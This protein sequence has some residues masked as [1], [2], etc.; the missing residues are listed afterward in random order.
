M[1]LI[2]WKQIDPQLSGYGN[3]TGSLDISGSLRLNGALFTGGGGS[4][5]TLSVNG[6]DLSI[7]GGNTVTLPSGSGGSASTGSLINSA[8][9]TGNIIT[10]TKG[11]GS[12]FN[13]TIDTGSGGGS[14]DISALN[15]FTSSIQTEVDTLTAATSSY[16][17]SIDS[18]IVSSSAQVTELLP[19]GVVSGSSQITI[20]ES[21][22]SD[23]THYADSDVKTKLD[24]EGVLSGSL[25]SQLPTGIISGSDQLT[26]SYD[27]RY[28]LSGSVGGG[29]TDISALN[30]FTGSIQTQVDSLES[31]TGSYILAS[32]TSSMTVLSASYAVSSSH[33]IITEVSSSH[34][35]QADTA[36]FISDTFISES[37]VR[38][39][40]GSGGS[41]S[42]NVSYD[43]DRIVSNEDL[44]D[45]FTNNYNAGTSGSIQDF[46]NAVFFPNTA[47]T[48]TNSANF[49]IDEFIVSG[50]SVGTLTATDPEGQSLTFS[51]ASAYTSDFVKVSTAGAVTLNRVPTT[52]DFNTDNRGDGTLAHPVQ[53][54]VTDTFNTT[55][56]STIY[57]NVTANSAPV[58]RQTS[59]VG[60]IITSFT[61]NRNEND[62]A[63][64]NIGRIYFTDTNSD[65]ITI[66]SQSDGSGHFSITK[67]SNYVQ[68]AQV[69]SSLDYESITSYT[70]SITGSD[71]HYEA[72]QDTDAS[73]SLA[74]TIN[75]TDNLVP[76]V[77]NQTLDSISE[78]SSN[79]AT[80]DSITASDNE[81]DTIT[82]SNFTLSKL[83][84]DNV[85]V[86]TGSYGGTSQS[87]PHED[88]FQ[89]NS[90]GGVTRKTG[91]YINSDIINEYQYTVQVRD[92]Y[93]TISSPATITIPIT[94][95][96]A[97]SIG[98]GSSFYIIESAVNGDS[99]YDSTN[100]Y[101]GTTT[102]FTSNQSVTWTV[103]PTS[104][105]AVD[106]SGYLT[107]NRNISGSADVGG[108]QLNG[109]VT[110]SNGFGTI[111]QGTFTVNITDNTAPTITFTNTSA[112][113]NT[114]GARPSNTLV[115]ISF[116]DTEG[117]TID[118]TSFTFTDPSNQLT[119]TQSGNTF[120]VQPTS[121]LSGSTSYAITASIQDSEGFATRTSNHSFT[122]VQAPIGSLTTNG[123][124]RIIESAQSGSNIVTN[125]NGIPTGTQADLGVS[126]SPAYNSAVVQSFTSSNA[127]IAVDGSG[128]LSLGV[129]ISG[130]A[131]SSG[132]TIQSSIT[133][134]DQY[135]NIGSGSITINV[136][137]NTAP[138]VTITDNGLNT[139]TAVSGSNI[140]SIAI[141]DSE[142]DTPF[143]LSLTGAYG[144]SFN[145]IPQNAA[146]SS[147]VLQPTAS[148]SQ[149]SYAITASAQDTFS[150]TGT[151]TADITVTQAADYG[152]VYVYKVGNYASGYNVD[153][154]ISSEVAGT[155]PT[156]LGY[157]GLGFVTSILSGSL[158]SSSFTYSYGGTK[159]ASLAESSSGI[160]ALGE[161]LVS[162]STIPYSSDRFV[163]IAPS[164]SD[165]TVP[166][167]MTDSYGGSTDGEYV[168]EAATDGTA[169]GSGLGTTETS[170][171]HKLSLL[172]AHEGF[173]NWIMIGP[174][175]LITGT[176]S[177]LLDV[178]TSSGSA[179]S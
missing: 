121:N 135:D 39:G 50:S 144:G 137:E 168:L 101:S 103:N 156:A 38:S 10:F 23:L 123:T 167:S 161:T 54:K 2:K 100:G 145:T 99:V 134:R 6:Y 8:S 67:Y 132:D 48:F 131:T 51:T 104:D 27:S 136:T 114:N 133:Y 30:T 152:V 160:N 76:V 53:V 107:I 52:E 82:F 165:L 42:A 83:E 89:M 78:N 68:I 70:L 108:D 162:M 124:F 55:T 22:I 148:L 141:S 109:S 93:N 88:P 59:A 154:G 7:S 61:I 41:G 74:I 20:T 138:T 34:A 17:T 16:L 11:D 153:L 86:A 56:T 130:S 171:I 13:I 36:S 64:S 128:G 71:E 31:A 91:V 166:S 77:N 151:D 33:E 37:A 150:K 92:N 62:T 117:D 158:G 106:S 159:T 174:D 58:F 84:L 140:A 163:I 155:P 120:L 81:S 176:T 146:S 43:G 142:S 125:A 96:P 178:R 122:I 116:S 4:V 40:F 25:V 149:G 46:L 66:R 97:P 24:T 35:V 44:G 75:V 143:T 49:T 129:N 12:T 169:L 95:D 5:Q 29:S 18:G 110:A 69:T 113:L 127:A 65:T 157:S 164:G 15:T 98:G 126:Y 63:N 172:S 32:Q 79:G 179:P 170:N 72:A 87:D 90:S 47:P 118:L 14:T 147:W 111:S 177:L 9:A 115:T 26:S 102:R 1:A 45:L 173:S 139:D 28:A 85:D 3:L 112:N 80:V 105:F 94:D 175:S 21:Q 57:I 119:T 19:T 73:S 60:S